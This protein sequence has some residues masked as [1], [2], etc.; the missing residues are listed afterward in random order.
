MDDTH[1][2]TAVN[3]SEAPKEITPE[4]VDTL[5]TNFEANVEEFIEKERKDF[6][7][8]K[9]HYSEII[10]LINEKLQSLSG[11]NDSALRLFLSVKLEEAIQKVREMFESSVETRLLL[12][13]TSKTG[14]KKRVQKMLE[15]A[16]QLKF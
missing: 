7:T 4:L 10:L 16:K 13:G 15:T 11:E 3:P 5:K 2:Q 12:Q 9:S 1:L 8:L 6:Q 14:A